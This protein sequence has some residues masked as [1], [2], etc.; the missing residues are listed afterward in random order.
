MG[1]FKIGYQLWADIGNIQEITDAKIMNSKTY[2]FV[3]RGCLVA[4][5][6]TSDVVNYNLITIEVVPIEIVTTYITVFRLGVASGNKSYKNFQILN[7]L[8]SRNMKNTLFI[9]STITV[10]K[11]L[12]KSVLRTFFRNCNYCKYV[13]YSCKLFHLQL[14]LDAESATFSKSGCYCNHFGHLCK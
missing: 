12:R 2:P 5:L 4:Y 13:N 11:G 10:C 14:Q 6:L 7:F 9:N 1:I 8:F 3:R